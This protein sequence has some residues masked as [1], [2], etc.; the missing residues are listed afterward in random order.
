MVTFIL[1]RKGYIRKSTAIM[2]P[3]FVL[4]MCFTLT[5][6]VVER[7]PRAYSR[8]NL[9][10]LWSYK[11]ILN[12]RTDLIAENFWNVMLFVPI[13]C[14]LAVL[15]RKHSRYAVITGLLISLGIELYQLIAHKGLFEFDDIIHNTAGTLLGVAICL[16]VKNISR[17]IPTRRP[18]KSG[19]AEEND[20]QPDSRVEK[21]S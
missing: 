8:Y 2:L 4:Y 15:F 17:M 13:G 11:A 9:E 16:L 5:I 10:L 7:Y 12:G 19:K 6:T 18:S 21:D 1:Y 20:L 14:L 3:L